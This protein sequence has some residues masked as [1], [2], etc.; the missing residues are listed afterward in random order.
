MLRLDAE[1]CGAL[2]LSQSTNEHSTNEDIK[3]NLDTL[4]TCK[5]EDF[6]PLCAGESHVAYLPLDYEVTLHFFLSAEILV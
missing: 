3:E 2:G 4:S 1:H 6:R 5:Q